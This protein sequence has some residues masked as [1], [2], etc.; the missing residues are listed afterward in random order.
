[1][2]PL[3]TPFAHS[4]GYHC[5][6]LAYS[7]GSAFHAA[8]RTSNATLCHMALLSL[9][10]YSLPPIGWHI[11]VY[12]RGLYSYTAFVFT[13]YPAHIVLV[14]LWSLP[15]SVSLGIVAPI[16][17]TIHLLFRYSAVQSTDLWRGRPFPDGCF[18]RGRSFLPSVFRQSPYSESTTHGRPLRLTTWLYLPAC[19]L[20]TPA[21]VDRPLGRSPIEQ[22]TPNKE[23]RLRVVQHVK[24][25][26][27]RL[28]LWS[29]RPM[30]IVIHHPTFRSEQPGHSAQPLLAVPP[31]G[32]RWLGFALSRRETDR[33]RRLRIETDAPICVQI[34]GAR[35]LNP[36]DQ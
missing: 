30:T 15:P 29:V 22:S 1:M 35:E 24:E 5:T 32:G 2:R 36:P 6:P 23:Q 13:H 28:G 9:T 16:W 27:N 25:Q 12:S 18:L 26:G 3:T 14:P 31:L 33:T 34:V 10:A 21:N 20:S 19:T 4:Q 17:G 7:S 8:F 11:A